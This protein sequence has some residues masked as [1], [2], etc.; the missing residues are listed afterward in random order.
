MVSSCSSSSNRPIYFLPS[1]DSAA[2]SALDV[3]G[4]RVV[5]E[6]LVGGLLGLLDREPEPDECFHDRSAD[7]VTTDRGEPLVGATAPILSRS[8]QH[9]PFGVFLPTWAPGSAR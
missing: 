9:Q 8:V 1:I 6:H 7:A 4:V 5:G 3:V 2:R